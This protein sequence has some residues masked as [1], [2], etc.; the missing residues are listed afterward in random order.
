MPGLPHRLPIA[1]LPR[2]VGGILDGRIA[3]IGDPTMAKAEKMLGRD[4]RAACVVGADDIA[5]IRRVSTPERKCIG[6]PEQ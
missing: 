6:G 2:P 4:P 1:L 5:P 3:D